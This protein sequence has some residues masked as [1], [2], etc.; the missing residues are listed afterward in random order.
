M[1][2]AL[3]WMHPGDQRILRCL[4]DHSPEYAAIV[5]NRSGMAPGYVERRLEVLTESGFVDRG[6]DG[7]VCGLTER[8]E[9]YLHTKE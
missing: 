1:S 3:E 8:G 5:A 4:E 9:R 6:T 7:V 2:T